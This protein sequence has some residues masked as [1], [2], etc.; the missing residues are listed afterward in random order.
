MKYNRIFFLLLTLFLIKD[1]FVSAQNRRR[2]FTAGHF[3]LPLNSNMKG[4]LKPF[5]KGDTLIYTVKSFSDTIHIRLKCDSIFRK[6]NQ[7]YYLK[8]K[9]AK[10]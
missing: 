10:R 8:Y 3:Q 7:H 1:N 9:L 6:D 5:V 2:S 4:Y